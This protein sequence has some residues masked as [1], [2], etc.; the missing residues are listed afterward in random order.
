M[1]ARKLWKRR[2]GNAG[3]HRYFY[4]IDIYNLKII[5]SLT[6]KFTIYI[7]FLWELIGNK[8]KLQ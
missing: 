8:L 2:K 6:K 7:F 4:L 1:F 5:S 3:H